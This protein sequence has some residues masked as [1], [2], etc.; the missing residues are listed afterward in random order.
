MFV[1]KQTTYKAN[2]INTK[3]C[4]NPNEK[5]EATPENPT[6]YKPNPI[7]AMTG[8]V[9]GT[10]I[11]TRRDETR[12][13]GDGVS[14]ICVKETSEKKNMQSHTHAQNKKGISSF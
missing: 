5:H 9:L 7:A 2:K 4:V 13:R 6:P 12:G 11:E 14:V 1:N 3:I 8:A 10:V